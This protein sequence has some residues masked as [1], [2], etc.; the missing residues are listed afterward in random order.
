MK[1]MK[2]VM[3]PNDVHTNSEKMNTWM[4]CHFN[5]TH[6]YTTEDCGNLRIELEQM[7]HVGHLRE[8]I[9]DRAKLNLSRNATQRPNPMFPPTHTINMVFDTDVVN[10]ITYTSMR[11]EGEGGLRKNLS[12]SLR[13]SG[14]FKHSK[15]PGI[16]NDKA[17][18]IENDDSF[19]KAFGPEDA[20]YG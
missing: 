10:K 16:E 12:K 20:L 4:W 6:G 15:Y 9:S 2:E 17:F 11:K 14:T 1:T 8:Y 13:V 18:L 19:K 3:F 7:Q 5:I